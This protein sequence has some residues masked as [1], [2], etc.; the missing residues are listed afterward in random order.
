MPGM[1]GTPARHS[2]SA[3]S[4]LGVSHQPMAT[5]IY[6]ATHNIDYATVGGNDVLTDVDAHS[7]W[8]E[9]TIM[10][11]ITA[12]AT[13]KEMRRWCAR[14]GLPQTVVSDNRTQFV[15][16]EFYSFLTSNSIQHVQTVPYHL[17]SNGFADDCGTDSERRGEK[18]EWGLGDT[19]SEAPN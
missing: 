2:P 16:E 17:S 7:K 9:A 8:I 12:T 13:V 14:Y 10:Q 18:D 3:H 1:P 6:L 5:H 4:P 15:G 19:S 11:S